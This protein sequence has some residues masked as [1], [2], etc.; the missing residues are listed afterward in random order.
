MTKRPEIDIVIDIVGDDSR[1]LI[2][3]YRVYSRS[4]LFDIRECLCCM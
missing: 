3:V 4:A 1:L 2:G